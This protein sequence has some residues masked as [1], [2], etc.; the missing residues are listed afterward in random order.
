MGTRFIATHESLAKQEYKQAIVD[1]KESD[2]VLTER[3][4]GIPLS[5]IRTPYVDKIGT[6]ISPISKMLF[7]N[8]LTKKLMRIWYGFW[9]VKRFKKNALHGGSAKDYWRQAKASVIFTP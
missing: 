3:V 8:R 6:K 4:T 5:V 7:K 1:A 9:A 2:I